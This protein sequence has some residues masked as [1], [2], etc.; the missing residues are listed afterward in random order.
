MQYTLPSVK[1]KSTNN[2]MQQLLK[3]YSPTTNTQ[4]A[5]VMSDCTYIH[6]TEQQNLLNLHTGSKELFDGMP[7]LWDN[8]MVNSD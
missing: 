4:I 6:A 2:A 3:Y 8:N 7:G 5:N 1:P